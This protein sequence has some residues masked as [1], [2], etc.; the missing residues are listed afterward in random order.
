[1]KTLISPEAT[2]LQDAMSS[3]THLIERQLRQAQPMAMI[4]E[5]KTQPL[6]DSVIAFTK[7]GHSVGHSSQTIGLSVTPFSTMTVFFNVICLP[8]APLVPPG[9]P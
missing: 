6:H 8:V 9:V 2:I 3:T 4:E 7:Q 1:M 5:D